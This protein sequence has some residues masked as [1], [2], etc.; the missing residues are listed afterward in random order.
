MRNKTCVQIP[1]VRAR[2]SKKRPSSAGDALVPA[3]PS[4][5]HP[6]S[7]SLSPG[8]EVDVEL[9][10][11]TENPAHDL[12]VPCPAR[13]GRQIADNEE[14]GLVLPAGP[15]PNLRQWRQRRQMRQWRQWRQW[16]RRR[17]W[18]LL[19]REPDCA[20][21]DGAKALDEARVRV[22]PGRPER[23]RVEIRLVRRGDFH[24]R[25]PQIVAPV[26]IRQV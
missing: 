20:G 2:R 23:V 15:G 25:P 16:R 17:W 14:E 26:L 11:L 21:V 4:R 7:P 9:D 12:P 1:S 13:T 5:R 22:V 18:L 3:F 10:L 19:F 24:Q 8:S 6:V